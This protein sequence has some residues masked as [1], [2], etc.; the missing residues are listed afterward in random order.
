MDKV[1]VIDQES[2][3]AQFTG[4]GGDKE[5]VMDVELKE[6]YKSGWFGNAK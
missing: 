6:E 2:E 3:S 5:K 4:I 1:K